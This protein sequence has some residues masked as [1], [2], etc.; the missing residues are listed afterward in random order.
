MKTIYLVR[1]GESEGNLSYIFQT[2]DSPLTEKGR[3]QAE[4]IAERIAKLPAEVIIASPLARTKATAEIIAA[5]VGKPVEYSD[6]LIERRIMS[7]LW[8]RPIDDPQ[9]ANIRQALFRFGEPNLR[10]SDEENFEDLKARV[11]ATLL[12]LQQRPENHILV[13]GHG[14]FTRILVARV[15][16]GEKLTGAECLQILKVLRTRNTGLSVL[17]YKE[18]VGTGSEGPESD[19]QL[20]VW[21]DHAHLG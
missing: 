10:H 15:L 7:E 8:G 5:R 13:I 9:I 20:L 12:Y 21:N 19:W 14:L 6:L 4:F 3:E 1:H 16:M 2:K 11:D 17:H 18:N